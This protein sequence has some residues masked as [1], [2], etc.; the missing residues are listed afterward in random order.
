M[1]NLLEGLTTRMNHISRMNDQILT[2]ADEADI[3]SEIEDALTYSDNITGWKNAMAKVLREKNE[4][5]S[6]TRVPG[7]TNVKSTQ[8]TCSAE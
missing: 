5:K 1:E 7:R 6:I 3:T 8:S 2:S 4:C